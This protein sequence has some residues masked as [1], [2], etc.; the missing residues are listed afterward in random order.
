MIVNPLDKNISLSVCACCIE[1]CCVGPA[2][3]FH[4]VGDA[5]SIFGADHKWKDRSHPQQ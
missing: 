4:P 5:G 3:S 1:A 2:R